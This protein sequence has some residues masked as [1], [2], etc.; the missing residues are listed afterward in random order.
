MSTPKEERA[1]FGNG[2]FWCTEAVFTSLK[3]VSSVLPG[4]ADGKSPNPTYFRVSEGLTGHAEVIEV[5]FDPTIITYEQLLDVFWH[6][7]NPTTLNQQGADRGIQYRST[8]L[9]ISEAQKEAAEKSKQALVESHEF[10][11]PVV[12]TIKPLDHFYPAEDYHHEYYEKNRGVPYCEVIITPKIE[13]FRRR[14]HEL[15]KD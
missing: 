4:Y 11:D 14:Y 1:Y 10:I 7:H 9:Y 2:C 3:G 15:L 6:T 12:T 5:V 13:H 8:I